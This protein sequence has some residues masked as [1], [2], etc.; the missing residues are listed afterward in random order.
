MTTA[1]IDRRQPL[2]LFQSLSRLAVAALVMIAVFVGAFVIGRGSTP[3]HTVRSVIT[4]PATS[5]APTAQ[6][7]ENCH[8]G[9]PC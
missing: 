9:Q 1:T 4:V 2:P 8:V 3:T 6:P 7:L 5:P